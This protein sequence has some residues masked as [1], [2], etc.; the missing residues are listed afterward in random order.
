MTKEKRCR[1]CGR[2]ENE[3]RFEKHRGVCIEC[4]HKQKMERVYK[5]KEEYYSYLETCSCKHCGIRNPLVLQFHH[6]ENDKVL[7]I[8]EMINRGYSW[9]KIKLEID[10]CDV[11]CANC[12]S[13]ITVAEADNM[14]LQRFS[15]YVP[16]KLIE[17]AL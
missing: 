15:E 12:H 10:K 4:R 13:I 9:K 1:I 7:G 17:L 6:R 8:S 14:K 5:I 2:S 11:Y 3:V 16:H